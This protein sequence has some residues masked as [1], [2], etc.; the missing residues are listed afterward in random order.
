[1]KPIDFKLIVNDDAVEFEAE[2]NNALK[3]G[4]NFLDQMKIKD[5]VFIY[6]MIKV[7]PITPVAIPATKNSE[8]KG[9]K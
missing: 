2:V 6:A 4:Y 9:D 3:D 1:M 8:K 5:N 7:E